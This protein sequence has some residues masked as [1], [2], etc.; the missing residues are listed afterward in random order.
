MLSPKLAWFVLASYPILLLI[1]L[2]LPIK[3]IKIM[4][5]TILLVENLLVIALFLKGKYFA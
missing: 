2:L 5:C 3:N 4:V 1:S